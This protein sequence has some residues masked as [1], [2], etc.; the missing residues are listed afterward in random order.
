M[1]VS[2]ELCLNLKACV[3]LKSRYSLCIFA[4]LLY[5]I[6]TFKKNKKGGFLVLVPPPFFF[7]LSLSTHERTQR[8]TLAN[9]N[10]PA[11]RKERKK[12]CP[13]TFTRH[14]CCWLLHER[15]PRR[16]R[17]FTMTIQPGLTCLCQRHVKILQPAGVTTASTLYWPETRVC[18]S[19]LKALVSKT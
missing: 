19:A 2:Q 13:L 10:P 17:L 7:L 16:N 1:Y 5:S 4:R 15:A 8:P 14:A 6:A 18:H 12:K 3:C 11:V 9:K